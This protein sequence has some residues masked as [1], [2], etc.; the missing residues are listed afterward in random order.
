MVDRDADVLQFIDEPVPA[1]STA[2]DAW[3]VLLVDDEPDVHAATRLALKDVQVQGRALAFHHAYTAAQARRLLAELPGLAVAIVDVVM[4]DED[5]GLRLVRHLREELGNRLLRVILRTGQPGYAPEIETIRAYDI[6]DYATKSEATQVRLFTSLTLAVRTYEQLQALQAGQRGLAHILAAANGLSRAGDLAGYAQ[7]L[8]RLACELLE[9]PSA[10]VVGAAAKAAPRV[11]A[12]LGRM[13]PWV[14]RPLPEL[15][16]A[17]ARERL[18][19]L[20]VRRRHELEL[21]D[22]VGLFLG[23]RSDQALAILVELPR[24]LQGQERELLEAFCGTAAVALENLQLFLAIRELAYRDGLVQLP[25]RNALVDAIDTGQAD[26]DT[27]AL[28]DLDGFAD[29]NSILDDSFGDAVLRAVAARLR[30]AFPAQTLVARVGAD[31]F[32]LYGSAS[33]VTPQAIAEVFARPF[34]VDGDEPLR[35]SATSGLVRL[36]QGERSGAAVLKNAGAALKQAKR[37]QRGK[38]LYFELSQADAARERIHLLSGLRSAFSEGRLF[39][40]YQPFVHLRSGRVVGAE[41]LLRWRQA[42]GSLVSPAE[43]IPVAEQSGLMVAIGQWV[44]RSAMCWRAGLRDQV[45]PDFRVAVNVSHVQ[46]ADPGFVSDFL[47]ALDDT[48]LN[49]E[50][51]EIE[52]TES[53]AIENT[54]ALVAKLQAL[55]TRGVRVAMDDFGTGYSSLS[56]IQGLPLDRLK[57]DRSFVSGPGGGGGAGRH[58]IA[59]LVLALAAQLRLATLAEGIENADQHAAL[60]DAGCEEGQGYHFARPLDAADFLTWLQRRRALDR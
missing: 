17:R 45:D 6:N 25:N 24:A 60:Q 43:F 16:E 55:R 37:G 22:G 9:A 10:C 44:L 30:D 5:A 34:F 33:R 19:R 32:A 11:L 14:D 48:G 20:L 36:A 46:F 8:A 12:A 50:Q 35:L 13:A 29:I 59:R 4:E 40:Q 51:I 57:V 2:P 28:V 58:E 56:V 41:T 42:D 47:A 52:L 49:G 39:L 27:V 23:G 54:Q 26:M 53:V 3:Q 7:R 21:D 31:L 1:P 18:Q 15:P 38:A